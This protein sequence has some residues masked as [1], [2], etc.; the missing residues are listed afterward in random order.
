MK[1][2]IYIA[3]ACLIG[4]SSMAQEQEKDTIATNELEEVIVRGAYKRYKTETSVSVARM[5]LKNLENP[6]IYT[7]IS[8]NLLQDQLVTQLD[9]ALRNATGVSRLWESTGRGGDGAAFFSLRGFSVQP[10]LTNSVASFSNM[11]LDPANIET[12]EVLKGPSG[13]LFGGNIVS[14]GG[15]INV[16]TKKPFEKEAGVLSYIHL[17][18]G[19]SRLS[20]DYNTPLNKDLAIRVNAAYQ[21]QQSFQN[22]GFRKS[23]FIAPSLSYR[24]SDR[25]QYQLNAEIQEVEGTY[26]PMIFLNRYAPLSFES[27]D[28]FEAQY[29]EAFTSNDLVMR[30]PSYSFQGK[31]SVAISDQWQSETIFSS[32]NAKTDGYYQYLWDSS[33]GNEF[34]RFISKRNGHTLSSGLQQNFIGQ[35]KLAGMENKL[36]VGIDYLDRKI[37]DQSSGWVGHGVVAITDQTDSGLLTSQAVDNALSDSYSGISSANTTSSGVYVSNVLNFSRKF[38]AM[39]SVRLD[40]FEGIPS[41]WAQESISG[42]TTL[43]PKFGLVYQAIEDKISF[44]GNYMNGFNQLDPTQVADVDGNNPRIKV[45]EAEQA[46]Q[47]E[48]GTKLNVLNDNATITASYYHIDVTNKLMTDPNNVNNNIQGGA[49]VSKG[50]EASIVTNPIRGL[51]IVAGYA[52]NISE[53]TQD[54]PAGGYLGLRPEEAG[55]ET[56]INFWANYNFLSGGLKNL[57]IGFGGNYASEHHTLNR[58]NIGQFTLP[59]YTVLNSVIAYQWNQ[60]SLQFKVD[61]LTNKRYFTGWSTV[62]PQQTRVVSLGLNY[63]F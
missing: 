44:F 60:A 12:I 29:L 23:F 34:T 62:S 58:A 14:Y 25:V 48:F 63:Q 10:T 2:N 26:A 41:Y 33:N 15:L 21:N 6:Q 50:F 43:S 17:G 40:Y 5:P 37:N 46:S 8:K 32:S 35:F 52:H 1:K 55:P 22:A 4:M 54:T 31:M 7:S 28:V 53:V 27:I 19:G 59:S 13:T 9:Q 49:V 47:Y 45:Y 42:Q 24:A 38:S 18:N 16:I 3:F 36:L 11:G 30:N 51:N 39:A 57:S 20:L 56:L 61:N